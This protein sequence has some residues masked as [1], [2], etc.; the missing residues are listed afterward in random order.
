MATLQCIG[1]DRPYNVQLLR[2]SGGGWEEAGDRLRGVVTCNACLTRTI[3]EMDTDAMRFIPEQLSVS[4][5]G[6]VPDHIA[7]TYDEATVAYHGHA[8]RAAAGMA[9]A[10]IEES[11]VARGIDDDAAFGLEGKLKIA[12]TR[13]ILTDDLHSTARGNK[14]VGDQA[15]HRARVVKATEAAAALNVAHELVEHIANWRDPKGR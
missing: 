1:C 4:F 6:G 11:L 3:F 14:L 9:R 10:A 7:E 13:G 8:Y 12:R 5:G 2:K 15:L